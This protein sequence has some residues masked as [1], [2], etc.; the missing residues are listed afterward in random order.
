MIQ[1][2]NG[3]AK[4]IAQPRPDGTIDIRQRAA[5]LRF[6]RAVSQAAFFPWVTARLHPEG[7]QTA[8]ET[9]MNRAETCFG[10]RTEVAEIPF[11]LATRG[12][13]RLDALAD[14]IAERMFQRLTAAQERNKG[15]LLDVRA[16]AEY[17]GPTP[18]ALRHLIATGTIP[19][20]V[21]RDGRV[22][23]DRQDLDNW[24]ELSKTGV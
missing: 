15:R 17:I 8:A 19:C 13:Q 4:F 3:K 16:A 9:I 22:Q 23:L 2:N 5:E 24:V 12:N 10:L 20:F 11:S 21:R 18:T 7:T 14:A 1:F 6:V